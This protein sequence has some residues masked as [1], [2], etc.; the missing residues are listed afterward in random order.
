MTDLKEIKTLLNSLVE[1]NKILREENETM[2][3]AVK[4][5]ELM[6][7][8]RKPTLEE[9]RKEEFREIMEKTKP[10]LEELW[11]EEF[12]EIMEKRNEDNVNHPAHYS[13]AIEVIDFIRDKLT[14]EELSGYYKGNILKYIARYGKKQ[15]EN[16][17]EDIQKAQVYLGWLIDHEGGISNVRK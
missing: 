7:C 4:T 1:Q 16:P 14:P 15:T 11:K 2:R 6:R 5:S 3:E 8:Q 13:G 9:L 12:Q 17:V 10:T